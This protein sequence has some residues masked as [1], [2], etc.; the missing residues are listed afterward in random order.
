LFVWAELPDEIDTRELLTEAV[1]QQQVAFVP[2]QS[3]YADRTG[4]NTMR[5]N[6]SNVP[7]DRIKQ[8]IE[9]LGRV[10]ER[11]LAGAP[12]GR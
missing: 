1:E 7:P 11:R 8:G 12:A 5:L 2:G 3:F 10:I 6:F 9:R 4:R